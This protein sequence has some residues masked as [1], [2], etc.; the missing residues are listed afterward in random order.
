MSA[1]L[2]LPFLAI[3]PVY[4]I[5]AFMMLTHSGP[6]GHSTYPYTLGEIAEAVAM[7]VFPLF[8]GLLFIWLALGAP[9]SLRKRKPK[10]AAV[11]DEYS[12]PRCVS[13]RELITPE[14]GTCPK[15]G[16]TQPR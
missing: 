10:T 9:A 2:A 6:G 16:W 3:F 4:L 12:G 1:V 14:T 8:Y 7:I 11:Q 13:C 15:C 5:L